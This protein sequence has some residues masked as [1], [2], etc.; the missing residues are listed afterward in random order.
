MNGTFMA[1][2]QLKLAKENWPDR[3]ETLENNMQ[4]FRMLGK[5]KYI[6]APRPSMVHEHCHVPLPVTAFYSTSYKTFVNKSDE[7]V[8][9]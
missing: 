2:G 7:F 1:L 6:V 3:V 9:V 4:M 8:F 5:V